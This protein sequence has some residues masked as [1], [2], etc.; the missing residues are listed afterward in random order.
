MT[1]DKEV[2]PIQVEMEIQGPTFLKG[3]VQLSDG[4]LF[5]MG[6]RVVI[7]PGKMLI[8]V[9]D[10]PETTTEEDPIVG[11]FLSFIKKDMLHNPASF[12]PLSAD[13]IDRAKALTAGTVVTDEDFDD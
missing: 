12:T 2:V 13:V 11:A 1:N 7:G 9:L 6:D 8:S 3:P 4:T 10:R 5:A